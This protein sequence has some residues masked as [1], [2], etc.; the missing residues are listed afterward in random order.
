[1]NPYISDWDRRLNWN[2][3]DHHPRS[4]QLCE[5]DVHLR[6]RR[7][8]HADAD[9]VPTGVAGIGRYCQLV[10]VSSCGV[11]VQVDERRML[12]IVGGWPVVMVRMIVPQVLVYVQR[13]AHGA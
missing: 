10:I 2:A 3:R 13:R 8:G 12:M 11:V 6:Y 4:R 1:V 7:A 9:C 5:I